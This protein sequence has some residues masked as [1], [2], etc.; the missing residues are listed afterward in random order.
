MIRL[1][2][3]RTFDGSLMPDVEVD[4][5]RGTLEERDVSELLAVPGY[6]DSHIHGSF[7]LDVSDGNADDL[8]SMAQKLPS[9]GVSV[10][11][12]TLMTLDEEKILKA[13][14]AVSEAA[15]RL[16]T[17]DGSYAAIAGLRLEGP[18]LSPLKAGVQDSD[19][20]VSADKLSEIITKMESHFPGLVRMI[21]IAPENDG[22]IDLVKEYKDRYVFS[23]AHS[24]CGYDKAMEFFRA[25]GKCIT[26][27]LNAMRPCLKR[28]PGPLGA[29]F[30]YKDS[31]IEVICDGHHVDQTVL[32][33]LFNLFDGRIAVISDAMRA[34]GMPDGTYGLGGTEVESRGGRTYF[35]PSGNLA[36]SVTDLSEESLRLFSYGV[37]EKSIVRALTHTPKERF[38]IE[39]GFVSADGKCDFNFVDKHLRLMC[40]ISRGRL[41]TPY[42]ML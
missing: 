25:G 10:F 6:F 42:I 9:F 31:Y 34:A 18:C 7:G 36:G 29:A 41:V 38:G 27:A 24:D 20:L 22:A 37:P 32:R 33:M 3:I 14:Q 30:D 26:H 15:E 13:A 23:L 12:P 5:G 28:D 35:G 1:K 21:D 4:D 2:N 16:R 40:V 39:N 11:L 8:V 19:S 17:F